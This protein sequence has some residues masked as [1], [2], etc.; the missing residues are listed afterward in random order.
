[1]GNVRAPPHSSGPLTQEFRR[2]LQLG[3]ALRAIVPV[4][5]KHA[6]TVY[7]IYGWVNGHTSFE[8]ANRTSALIDAILLEAAAQGD[9]HA[10]I[11]G[12]FN[13][14]L[15]DL[16]AVRTLQREGWIDLGADLG[17]LTCAYPRAML[18]NCWDIFGR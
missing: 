18:T 2:A 6:V 14:E 8:A 15:A 12:D 9:T 11:M 17:T 4:G 5:H 7:S 13:A 1:M 3:R 16:D 10:L